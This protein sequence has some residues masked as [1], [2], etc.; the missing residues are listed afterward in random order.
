MK[1]E[2]WFPTVVSVFEDVISEEENNYLIDN[3]LKMKN[4]R[5][6]ELWSTDVYNTHGTYEL[7]KDKKFNGLNKKIE[8]NTKQFA[9]ELGSDDAY[10]ITSSWYNIYYSGDF[11]EYHYHEDNIFSAVYFFTNPKDSGKLV[12]KS[13]IKDMFQLKKSKTNDLTHTCA[14]YNLKPRSLIIFRSYLDHMVEKC[15]NK[16]PRITAAYNLK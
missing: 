5:G 10:K 15:Y 7:T 11:Q 12:F 3:I 13:P 6:G 2:K 16:E 1:I 8:L 4:K 9:K 14:Y